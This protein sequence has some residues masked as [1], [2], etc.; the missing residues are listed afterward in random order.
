VAVD[1]DGCITPGEG[2][3][4][5]IDA[6]RRL[7]DFNGR[8]ATD[9]LVPAVTLCTGRQQPFVDLMCQIIGVRGP[10]IF[11]NG[12]GLHFPEPYGFKFHPAVTPGR[13][14]ELAKLRALIL[15][16]M[17]AAG[18]TFIQPGKE[19]SLSVYPMAGFSV[20][21][22]AADLRDIMACNGLEFDLD[23]SL[24]CV[25]IL[26]PG[27]DKTAGFRHLAETIG[28]ETGEIGAIGDAPGDLGYLQLSGFPGVP[29]NAVPELKAVARYVS[30]LE[31]G[32]G[33]VDI[34]EQIIQH[35]KKQ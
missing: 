17:V 21:Q 22:N 34:I 19:A 14:A 25:N 6:L 26:M 13:L 4:A 12:A 32:P 23:V 28:L 30:L 3:A 31:F 5:D 29:Q 33:S 18:R 9:P 27:I 1:I 24:C 15:S 11:E 7:R 35:N 10:A 20:E 2:H 16:E 8:A